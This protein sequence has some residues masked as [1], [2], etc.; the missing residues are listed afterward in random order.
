MMIRNTIQKKSINPANEQ[1]GSRNTNNL[2]VAFNPI[3]R[4]GRTQEFAYI[5]IQIQSNGQKQEF[6]YI[7][8]HEQ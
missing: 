8:K 6:A 5:S 1:R 2:E 3:Q 4:M 7:S